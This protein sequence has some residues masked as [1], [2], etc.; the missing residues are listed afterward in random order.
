M[1]SKNWEKILGE[2]EKIV[3]EFSLAKKYLSFLRFQWMSISFFLLVVFLFCVNSTILF[4]KILSYFFFFIAFLFFI[5]SL[6]LPWYL[7]KTNQFALTNRRILAKRGW[8]SVNL[9]SIPYSKITDISV[10]QNF[11]EKT[12][13]NS[14]KISIDTAGSSGPEL[15]LEKIENPFLIKTK[16]DDAY[17]KENK[18][19]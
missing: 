6:Y 3:F 8:L 5:I 2:G 14:G 10:T 19:N 1:N 9:I 12:L 11:W 16:I 13:F 18:E 15:I 17:S 4:V 7:R